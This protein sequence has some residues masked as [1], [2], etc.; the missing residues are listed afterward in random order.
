VTLECFA[1]IIMI[2]CT[3]FQKKNVFTVERRK[4]RLIEGNAK[5]P[6]LKKIGL[7]RDRVYICLWPRTPYPPPLHTV[8][9]YTNITDCITSL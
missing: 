4:L 5:C 3:Y 9:V 6:H 7:K 1:Y 8:Y 2:N